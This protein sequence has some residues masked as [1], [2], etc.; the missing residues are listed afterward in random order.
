[1]T[2]GNGGEKMRKGAGEG[3]ESI[4][5]GHKWNSSKKRNLL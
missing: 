2:E 1:M 3:V 5:S 4:N